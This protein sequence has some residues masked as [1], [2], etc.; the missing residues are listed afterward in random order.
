M[1]AKR[2]RLRLLALALAVLSAVLSGCGGEKKETVKLYIKVP[3]LT[4]TSVT[5]PDVTSAEQFLQK[6]WDAFAAQYEKYDVSAKV[7]AFQQTDYDSAITD[8]YGTEYAADVLYGGYFNISGY[9][10]DGYAAPLDGI[11]TDSI[12]ADID[13]IYWDISTS[14]VNQKIYLMPYLNLQN[15]LCYNKELF[16]LC[17]L[18]ALISD[19]DEIQAWTLEEWDTVLSTLAQRLPE[20][21]YPM[22]MYAKNNQGD[23]HTMVQLRVAGSTFFDEL[24]RFHLDTPE[25]IAGL[26]WLK[27]NYDKGYYPPHCEDLEINDCAALF[28]NQQSAIHVYNLALNSYY[29][30]LDLGY[31]NFPDASGEGAASSFLTGFMAFDNGDPQKLEVAED[32]IQYIYQTEQWMDYSTGGIPCSKAVSARHA[33]EIFMGEAFAANS[34]RAVDYTANNPNW[35]GVRD[36]FYPHIYALLTGG[37]TAAQAAAGLDRDCNAAIEAGRAH[38]RLHG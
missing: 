3:L 28:T 13:E 35:L 24:G 25:G 21:T 20:N 6:A 22:M 33:G 37:E 36:A 17:G 7:I 5:D 31:V 14:P 29:E 8:C 34:A 30:S 11:V 10:Y 16:R 12:R 9:I 4:Q 2:V 38:S 18:D 15:I 26:Q 32:F 19:R 27:D 1:R 23:T